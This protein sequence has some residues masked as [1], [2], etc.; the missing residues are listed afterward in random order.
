MVKRSRQEKRSGDGRNSVLGWAV[1]RMKTLQ[2][3][4]QG[5]FWLVAPK[6]APCH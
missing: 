2:L 4:T 6:Q 1:V 3:L 5:C